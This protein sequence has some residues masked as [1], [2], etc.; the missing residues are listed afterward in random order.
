MT[1]SLSLTFYKIFFSLTYSPPPWLTLSSW[2][3]LPLYKLLALYDLLSLYDLL[4]PSFSMTH[5]FCLFDLLS[6]FLTY[7]PSLWPTLPLYDFTTLSM[8]YSP[9]IWLTLPLYYWLAFSMTLSLSL[10]LSHL[11]AMWLFLFLY[12]F[13]PSIWPSTPFMIY[14]TALTFSPWL[15]LLCTTYSS[16]LWLTLSLR[17]TISIIF[18]L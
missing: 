10:S 5:F 7:Y 2:F 14:F 9:S 4:N 18:S 16:S 6:T 15:T 13:P 17:L 12:D 11:L 3:T 8:T 1:Y